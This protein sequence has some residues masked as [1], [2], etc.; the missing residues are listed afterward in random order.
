MNSKQ[1]EDLFNEGNL[2]NIDDAVVLNKYI[3]SAYEMLTTKDQSKI[4]SLTY[5]NRHFRIVPVVEQN[6][7]QD[8][9]RVR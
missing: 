6:L 8:G 7:D 3:A 1:H 5:R 4:P 9:L 2:S